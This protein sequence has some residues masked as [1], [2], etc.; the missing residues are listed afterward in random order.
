MG[1]VG[2]VGAF[3][4]FDFFSNSSATFDPTTS[5]LFSR[6]FDGSLTRLALTNSGGRINAACD[7]DG[8]TYFAGLFTSLAGL[9][10]SLADTS[11]TNIVSYTSSS[12][13]FSALTSS[14]PNGEIHSLFCDQPDKK[15]WAGG[16]FTSP[17]S[18]VAV[19]DPQ[20]QS[21]SPPPFKG[22]SGAQSRVDSITT[23]SSD[24]SI[25]FAGSFVTAFGTGSLNGTHNPNVPFSTGATPFSSSL[26]PVPLQGAEIDGSP[27][28]TDT[29][30]TNIQS[31]LCPAGPDGPGNSW[32]AIDDG[33][34]LI[35]IRAF[36]SISA[37]GVRL[38]NTFQPNHGT[39]EFRCVCRALFHFL[40]FSTLST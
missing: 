20:A 33:T 28:T 27:S 5:T 1:Q 31:I 11:A 16:S 21:W 2:L 32:F 9:F 36:S 12:N 10:T 37:S 8:V 35:T 3:A 23:N 38:G 15:V 26:V 19:W 34:P 29:G 39:T 6:S 22:F 13:S 25:F 17:G 24:T 4:G 7:L 14:S 40:S 18:A 30:F